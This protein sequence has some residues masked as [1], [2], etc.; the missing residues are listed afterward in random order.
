VLIT[1]PPIS[2]VE[3]LSRGGT[4]FRG[5]GILTAGAATFADFFLAMPAAPAGNLRA[6]VRSVTFEDL[7][8]NATRFL[9]FGLVGNPIGAQTPLQT[10]DL[11]NMN[12]KTPTNKA[13][14]TSALNPATSISTAL[15]NLATEFQSST[16]VFGT[17]LA[18]HGEWLCVL[19]PGQ[20]LVMEGTAFND[21]YAVSIDWIELEGED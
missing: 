13:A 3:A 10:T 14:F 4:A 11:G 16:G 12:T 8:S 21:L 19:R 20:T 5:F 17:T 2:W 6:Y 1:R 18:W 7:S 15:W 9:N